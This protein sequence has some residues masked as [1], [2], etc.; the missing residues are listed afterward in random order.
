MSN[1]TVT[2]PIS[3]YE[4][5]IKAEKEYEIDKILFENAYERYLDSDCNMNAMLTDSLIK[6]I[7]ESY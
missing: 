4:R 1:I 3:E 2:M 5:L 7:K 6:R